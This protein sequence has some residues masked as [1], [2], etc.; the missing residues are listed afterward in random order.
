MGQLRYNDD[1]NSIDEE[2]DYYKD[3]EIPSSIL[4]FINKKTD[5]KIIYDRKHN[6]YLCAKCFH[7]LSKK[8]YCSNCHQKKKYSYANLISINNIDE[9]YSN[10]T[11]FYYYA[12][13]IKDNNV[14]LY[15]FK[16][17]L[18]ICNN[19]HL[20]KV[21]NININEVLLVNNDSI[22]SLINS[23][24]YYYNNFIKETKYINNANS[25]EEMDSIDTLT[26]DFLF[27]HS[28]Y[29]Y[30][31][32]IENLSNTIYKYS[33]IWNSKKYLKD[34]DVGYYDLTFLPLKDKNFEYLMKYGL[35]SLAYCDNNLV[36]KN[37]FYNTFGLDK[38]YLDFMKKYDLYKDELDIL[39][40]FKK[41]DI[42]LIRSLSLYS[43]FLVMINDYHV[44][45]NK[46][47]NYFK[48]KK[49][50]YT[51]FAEY[52]D[53]LRMSKELGIDIKDKKILFPNN[54]IEEHDK[55]YLEYEE[56]QDESI[57]HDIQKM[58]EI[59]KINCYKDNDYVIFPARSLKDLISESTNQNNCVRTYAKMYAD[60][61]CFIYF[62]RKK[63]NIDKSLVT[64][65]VRDNK[66]VQAKIKNNNI[67]S[68]ELMDVI[69]KW[70]KT[71]IPISIDN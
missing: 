33:Y 26:T 20:Y 37:N 48:S 42:K 68:K 55:R 23:K 35:Y 61:E 10:N 27:C 5:D 50:K 11:Y 57:S 67:P 17:T 7:L 56:M 4:E 59:L 64:I 52:Y 53:Y 32:N 40:I 13:E 29:L 58:G 18:Y 39:R 2:I 71:L 69:K 38:S 46:L 63:D 41:K 15:E 22:L 70:E 45:M 65:E 1:L 36:F 43:Y 31:D 34:H 12:F 21:N 62:L 24:K 54:L 30:L 19:Y 6:N 44:D 51:Y 9:A 66:V 16:D 3:N 28:G 47:L 25:I 60:G 8:Y 14:L 49:I